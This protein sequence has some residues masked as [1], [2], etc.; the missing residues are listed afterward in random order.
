M[1]KTNDELSPLLLLLMNNWWAAA[2]KRLK[3]RS[4]VA[5]WIDLIQCLSTL[6]TLSR[7]FR[8]TPSPSPLLDRDQGRT[9]R[10]TCT[11]TST[12]TFTFTFTCTRQWSSKS[13]S[14]CSSTCIACG[15][16]CTSS[17]RTSAPLPERDTRQEKL[18]FT[19][20]ASKNHRQGKWVSCGLDIKIRWY[21]FYTTPLLLLSHYIIRYPIVSLFFFFFFFCLTSKEPT[22]IS[23]FMVAT[24]PAKKTVVEQKQ[25]IE[26]ILLASEHPLFPSILTSLWWWFM[27]KYVSLSAHPTLSTELPPW[28]AQKPSKQQNNPINKNHQTFW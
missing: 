26:F 28:G 14:S 25:H 16:T 4:N 12:F 9:A 1:H 17:L 22:V 5:M 3:G 23:P 8:S 2:D 24:L 7:S 15:S 19:T 20:Q 11:C 10:C 21:R 18:L 6:P 13:I 27:L